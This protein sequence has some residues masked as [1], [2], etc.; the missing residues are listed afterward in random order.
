LEMGMSEPGDISR[1][2]EIAPPDIAVLTYVALAHAAF[3]PGGLCQIAKEKGMIF[4]HPKTK[5]AI[6]HSDFLAFPE[7][8][9]KIRCE[10]RVV[11]KSDPK[12]FPR[13]QEPHILH[14]FWLAVSVA[15]AM[16]MRDEEI[17]ERLSFL[18]LPK[19]RFE[20]FEKKGIHFINDAYNANPCSLRAA[21]FSLGNQKTEGKRIAVLGTMKELGSFSVS[22][23][24]EIGRYAKEHVDYLLVLGEEAKPLFDCFYES[25]KEAEFFLDLQKAA[26]RLKEIARKGDAVLI[27]GSRSMNMETILDYFA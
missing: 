22:E 17:L 7:E 15:R 6:F 4:S 18:E 26:L 23:H 13:F 9:A 11:S 14:N 20:R 3:F 12:I 5:L 2:I 24:A 27:K 19:M 1:L 16:E 10:K 21:L 25:K 8:V